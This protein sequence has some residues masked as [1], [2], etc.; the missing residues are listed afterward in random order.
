MWFGKFT[1][2]VLLLSFPVALFWLP[3]LAIAGYGVLTVVDLL[4]DEIIGLIMLFV[5]LVQPILTL[6][7]IL[8]IRAG[9][10]ILK[11]T[12]GSEIGKLG[13][14]TWRALRF[15]IPIMSTIVVL[16]GLSSTITGLK[17]LDSTV[18][19]DFNRVTGFAS[20]FQA[21]FL[22]EIIKEFPVVLA[23][24]WI[25]GMCVAF[26][27]MAV[28]IAGSAAMAV[29]S[30]PNHH[31]IWGVGAQFVNIFIV[32][33]LVWFVPFV[34]GIFLIGGVQ[35]NVIT[36]FELRTFSIFGLEIHSLYFVGIYFLWTI[37]VM[38]AAAGVAYKIHLVND[39]IRRTRD[40]E[41]MAGLAAAD[42]RPAVDLKALRQARMGG[43]AAV[44]PYELD[45]EDETEEE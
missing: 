32:G 8:A 45:D 25:F 1:G 28:N 20:R 27:G 16:F 26:A 40:I 39:D 10:M 21:Y 36:L 31:Q 23:G 13:T 3:V 43:V 44:N 38:A 33:L 11:V 18:I 19:E 42:N 15:N 41:E 22:L 35:S 2:R 4:R 9:M 5:L 37:C 17:L 24:G 7:S 14:V 6:L 34:I 29:A 30:P 12:E